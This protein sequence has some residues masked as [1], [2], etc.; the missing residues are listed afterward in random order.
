MVGK[1]FGKGGSKASRPKESPAERQSPANIKTEVKYQK[2]TLPQYETHIALKPGVELS[3]PIGEKFWDDVRMYFES[4]A[5]HDTELLRSWF[6]NPERE[7]IGHEL[8]V[9]GGALYFRGESVTV[10]TQVKRIDRPAN[11]PK[12]YV[13][14]ENDQWVTKGGHLTSKTGEA[15]L[16]AAH[17][18]VVKRALLLAY[19]HGLIEESPL[20]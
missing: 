12:E 9:G 1:L 2:D 4:V 6:V 13:R 16:K 5:G 11:E 14:D 15:F 20:G 17:E 19:K 18:A 3:G 8:R 10:R 7:E